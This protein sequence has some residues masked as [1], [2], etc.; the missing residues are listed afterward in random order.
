LHTDGRA[1]RSA[2]AI[3]ALAYTAGN[4]IAFATDQYQPQ[5]SAGLRLFAH[6][7]THV[8]QQAGGAGP[9]VQ[10]QPAFPKK[11]I[12]I[13]GPGA[14]DLVQILTDCS[15]TQLSLDK[16][17]KLQDSG[18][19]SGSKNTS[20]AAKKQIQSLIK[21]PNGLVIDTDTDVPGAF[22]GSFRQATPG[23][24]NVNIQHIKALQAASGAGG[25]FDACSAVLHEISEAASARTLDVKG[26][27]PKA[28]I[29]KPSHDY[30]FDIENKIRADFKLPA[31]DKAG[32]ML[33]QLY[34]VD[35]SYLVSLFSN[36]F[37]TGTELR[38]QLSVVK[39]LGTMVNRKFQAQGN[40]ILAS[41]VEK[42][43]VAMGTTA[44]AAEALKKFFPSL[45]AKFTT[46]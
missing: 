24:H 44:E 40:E 29:F 10:R 27:T 15:G 1:A 42:G 38:T 9:R 2:R 39:T 36:V 8:V 25:G 35:N 21:N 11:G 46:P 43:T 5:S 34:L 31:R 28:D 26:K 3:N 6:E 16:D 19:K 37:G 14:K 33:A 20:A 32:S 30:G 18:K 23:F 45:N 13:T 41:H 4:H 12:Q 7:L 17:D 22:V